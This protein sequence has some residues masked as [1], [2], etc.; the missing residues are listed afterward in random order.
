[1]IPL[2]IRM[3]VTLCVVLLALPARGQDTR[4]GEAALSR[5]EH[6]KAL[7][8]ASDALEAGVRT[9]AELAPIYLL[10]AKSRAA[11]NDAEGTLRA[12]MRLLAVDPQ[13]RLDKAA[14]DALR[15]PYLEAR[16]FS[17]SQ[18][19]LGAEAALTDDLAGLVVTVSD[20]AQLAV[21]VRVRMRVPGEPAFGE[22]V[23]APEARSVFLLPRLGELRA[24]EYSIA[25]LDEHGNRIWQRGSDVEP[26]RLDA[27]APVTAARQEPASEAVVTPRSRVAFYVAGSLMLALGAG[28]AAGAGVA[29]AKRESLAS[30]WNSGRCGGTGETRAEL[31][32]DERARLSRM[33]MTAG[34]L[35]GF[36]GA[37]LVTGLVLML[38]EGRERDPEA[39]AALRCHDGP[40][41]LGI[42]CKVG[43]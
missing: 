28:A 18:P 1:M 2:R 37:S 7:R 43:F 23:R 5:G 36:G 3:F 21:R 17:A 4:A 11:L 15:S 10:E 14:P 40:G 33:Q 42:A 39:S 24:V 31:C 6:Q 20:P 16:G 34:L 12:F 26:L 38:V 27:P 32:A 9:G 30:D 8:L 25:L 29:H 19:P 13:F 41:E 35:Y 22:S